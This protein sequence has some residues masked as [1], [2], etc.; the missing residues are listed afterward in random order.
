MIK[1]NC[2]I[3]DREIS[4]SDI[5]FSSVNA[6]TEA[7]HYNETAELFTFVQAKYDKLCF[8]FHT[9]EPFRNKFI[10]GAPIFTQYDLYAYKNPKKCS[11]NFNYVVNTIK[12]LGV[13]KVDFLACE[14]LAYHEW[15]DYFRILNELTGVTVGASL[16]KTGNLSN[17]GDWIMES[18]NEDIKNLYF[19]DGILNYAEL[20]I[21]SGTDDGVSTNVSIGG[22]FRFNGTDY[23]TCNASSNGF[24]YFE[25]GPLNTTITPLDVRAHKVLAPFAGDLKTT[26]DGIVIDSDGTNK[27]TTITFNCYSTPTL[28]TNTLIFAVKLYWNNHSTKA[29]QVDYIYTSSTSRTAN[30]SGEYF[31]GYTD[32]VNFVFVP[33]ADDLTDFS[34][35]NASISSTNKFPANNSTIS[36]ILNTTPTSI[37][38]N[39]DNGI[40]TEIPLDGT[41]S[42]NGNYTACQISSNGSIS[43]GEYLVR[44]SYNTVGEYGSYRVVSPFNGNLKTTSDGVT[45]S[46]TDNICTITFN[47]YSTPS[48]TEN[49]LVFCILLYLNGHDDEGRIDFVYVSSTSRTDNFN[50]NYYIGYSGRE[51]NGV[52]CYRNTDDFEIEVGA[53][54][55]VSDNIFP[56]SGTILSDILNVDLGDLTTY[57]RNIDDG[58]FEINLGGTFN[59]GETN[60]T[61]TTISTNGYIQFQTNKNIYGYCNDLI[62]TNDGITVTRD[63]SNKTCTIRF[64]CYSWYDSTDNELVFEIVVYYNDHPTR[65]NQADLKYISATHTSGETLPNSS[66]IGYL[67]GSTHRK[68][69]SVPNFTVVTTESTLSSLYFPEAGTIYAINQDNDSIC[70][71]I[72]QEWEPDHTV[73]Y[74]QTFGSY[75]LNCAQYITGTNGEALGTVVYKLNSLDGPEIEI[76]QNVDDGSGE[77]TIYSIFTPN[78]ES[79]YVSYPISNKFVLYKID[80]IGQALSYASIRVGYT[81]T[82]RRASQVGY[83][84]VDEITIGWFGQFGRVCTK[85][86]YRYS[87]DHPV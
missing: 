67:A 5:F 68:I 28:T 26:G 62:T 16:D 86:Y 24:I 33:S 74:G 50:G 81:Y 22:T 31:I 53:S 52:T 20:L 63:D 8:V 19:T 56:A 57:L 45:L 46:T 1:Q 58:T 82:I 35:G 85:K 49:I 7:I 87:T 9:K 78:D 55:I 61:A 69:T 54:E 73:C 6:N 84:N 29:N 48:S 39:A 70:W 10:N 77:Y 34:R 23:T 65:P 72:A 38:K 18:T 30:F 13:Q 60:F 36:N 47:C 64:N 37:L 40:A 32:A 11:K 41:F 59:F 76:G 79:K 3:I 42:Y 71:Q 44:S 4:G 51:S 17:G 27:V 80:E 12:S 21:L 2:C 75:E 43:F 15:K 66:I 25:S 14:L 83:E